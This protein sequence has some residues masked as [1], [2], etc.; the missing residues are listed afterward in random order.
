T[1]KRDTKE[2]QSYY[3]A[4][5]SMPQEELEQYYFK[6]RQ[7][8]QLEQKNTIATV[9]GVLFIIAGVVGLGLFFLTSFAINFQDILNRPEFEE[10]NFDLTSGM[11][12]GAMIATYLLPALLSLISGIS[13]LFYRP[14]NN[15]WKG[16]YQVLRYCYLG[17]SLLLLA[18]IIITTIGW[19]F[20][21][22]QAKLT[23]ISFWIFVSL[24][25]QINISVI[26]LWGIFLGIFLLCIL[27][28]SSTVIIDLVRIKKANPEASML[29]RSLEGIITDKSRVIEE[30]KGLLHRI[31]Y[32]F[33]QSAIIKTLEL[34]GI[35]YL[36]SIIISTII[37]PL[38]PDEGGGPDFS[39]QDPFLSILSLGWAG[40]YEEITFRLLI[41]GVPMIFITLGRFFIEK[42][43]NSDELLTKPND[44]FFL[45]TP[46]DGGNSRLRITDIIFAIRGKYKRIGI[47]EWILIGIS[48][49]L[50]GFAHWEGWDGGWPAWKIIQATIM[51][52]FISYAFVK[53]GIEAAIFIHFTNNVLIGLSLFPSLLGIE[54]L[55]GF[56][57][58]FTT[59]LLAYGIMKFISIIVDTVYW[60]K[61][62][63]GTEEVPA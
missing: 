34:F 42:R 62:K 4:Q 52:F 36:V 58:V 26:G 46:Y 40:I 45:F 18:I 27:A 5:E 1:D 59:V 63:K 2:K 13:L 51:G 29:N 9:V 55:A 25:A 50:F 60:F 57:M 33:K 22:P 53:Y 16:F 21:N 23:S 17:F 14:D 48:S 37:V 24:E 44:K 49:L 43:K 56:G 39:D 38:F 35:S 47:P 32:L 8:A 54:W 31:F 19:T 3:L 10:L 12:Y 15:A 11:F 6:Q 28:L 30:K 7:Q 61:E 20:Y 41:I